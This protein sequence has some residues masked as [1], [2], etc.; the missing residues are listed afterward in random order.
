MFILKID[1]G[2]SE[3]EILTEDQDSTTDVENSK[4]T[5]A[6]NKTD[7]FVLSFNQMPS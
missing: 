5:Q 3:T 1:A 4:D 6:K 7:D 2:V